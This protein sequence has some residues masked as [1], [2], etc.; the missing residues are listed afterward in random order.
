MFEYLEIFHNRQRRLRPRDAHLDRIRENPP[1]QPTARTPELSKLGVKGDSYR[2]KDKQEEII[3]A[4]E[5]R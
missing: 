1:R 2:L 5:T 4:E 3:A